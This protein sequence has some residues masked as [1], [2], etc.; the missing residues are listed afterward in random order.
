LK[1]ASPGDAFCQQDRVFAR[2]G[3]QVSSPDR[4]I[5]PFDA[6]SIAFLFKVEEQIPGSFFSKF[7]VDAEVRG[8]G[9]IGESVVAVLLA[10]VL[11]GPVQRAVPPQTGYYCTMS[12]VL[13]GDRNQL[14]RQ[15]ADDLR[16]PDHP[17]S[18]AQ[19]EVWR[20]RQLC[21]AADGV[22]IGRLDGSYGPDT[23]RAENDYSRKNEGIP[24]NWESPVFREYVVEK[25]MKH[26]P[27]TLRRSQ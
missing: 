17:S 23:Q 19:E 16:M 12:A 21:L 6:G 13:T 26:P 1:T 11:S 8:V 27:T 5:I 22:G 7:S 24:V 2:L 3:V 4:L 10:G 14:I 15:A 20:S 25:A 9:R 18:E